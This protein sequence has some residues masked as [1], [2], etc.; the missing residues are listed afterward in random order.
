VNY[1]GETRLAF[2]GVVRICDDHDMSV[3]LNCW[4]DGADGSGGK[5]AVISNRIVTWPALSLFV[6]TIRK[7]E[8][9][10]LAR[11]WQSSNFPGGV[12]DGVHG[13]GLSF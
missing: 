6:G 9:N 8:Q 11:G 3:G 1:V 13:A 10:E 2:V 7:A 4:Q 5:T 12:E